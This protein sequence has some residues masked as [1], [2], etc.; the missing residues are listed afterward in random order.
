MKVIAVHSIVRAKTAT[1]P[2]AEPGTIF[3]SEG[4]ELK[5]LLDC[6][7]VREATS[8]ELKLHAIA[9]TETDAEGKAADTDRDKLEAQ[10]KELGVSF[11]K[12]T[13]DEKLAESIVEA[14]AKAEADAQAKAEA[15]AKD[16]G[17]AADQQPLV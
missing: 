16:E 8:D 3:E 17:K 13:S 2:R 6:R 1:P 10:A 4:A 9:D 12:N 14:E 15:D 7:A 11:R 5:Q